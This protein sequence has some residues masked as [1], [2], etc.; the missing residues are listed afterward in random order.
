MMIMDIRWL[1]QD[2]KGFLD[3]APILETYERDNLFQT[4]F[5]NAL[6]HEYWMMNLKKII[7]SAFIPWVTYSALSLIYFAHTLNQDFEQA[8]R[9][10]VMTW[11]GVGV[12][13][14]ILV[15]YLLY[16]EAL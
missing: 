13:I 11:Q 9:A 4:K 7:R 6:T 8:E 1:L 16:I 15:T 5:M 12:S 10:E 3:F 2:K 14:L